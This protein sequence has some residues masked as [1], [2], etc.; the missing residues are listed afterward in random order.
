MNRTARAALASETLTIIETRAYNLANG[1]S[2]SLRDEIDAAVRGSVIYRDADF[3]A[4]MRSAPRF[5]T[6]IAVT[7]ETTLA[8]AARL[9]TE[10]GDTPLLLNFASA[11][12]PGGGFLSGSQAQE[13]SLARSSALYACQMA[14][15]EF[16]EHNRAHGSALYSDWMIYSPDVPVFR[17]DDG[18]LLTRPYQAA[19]LTAPA[20]NAGAVRQNE[21]EKRA[22]ISV[23][24]RA[25]ASKLL[26][27]AAHHGHQRLVLGAWG[28][29]VF[30]NDPAA[31]SA[32]FADLLSAEFAGVFHEIVF[33][34]YD[35]AVDKSTLHAFENALKY[36]K[37]P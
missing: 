14:R 19:M 32:M 33:A 9:V 24:N 6:K 34:I 22:D 10:G 3:S 29:G 16:Y 1:Q 13:E 30:A 26:I 31:I 28:C 36:Q 12:N 17:S 21:P 15:F 25:R 5:A 37:S 35:P 8:A 7:P 18:A 11:R 27:V 2:V 20:V 23:V 4:L